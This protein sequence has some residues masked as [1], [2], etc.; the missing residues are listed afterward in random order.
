MM[1]VN[2]PVYL[3]EPFVRSTDYQLDVHQHIPPYPCDTVTEVERPKGVVPNVPRHLMPQPDPNTP[4][5][6]IQRPA[7]N[8]N[9]R[10]DQNI[11]AKANGKHTT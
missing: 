6:R 10:L 7:G 8:R 3:T 4:R 5:G 11:S 2:D 1:I 9:L